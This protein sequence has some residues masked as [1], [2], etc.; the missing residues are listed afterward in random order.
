MREIIIAGNWKMNT[1]P[2]E[3]L[4]LAREVTKNVEG[5]EG[6]TVVI[7]PPAT[8]LVGINQLLKASVAGSKCKPVELGAQNVHW[9]E[10]GAFTGE[11][12]AAMLE[13]L[14]CRWVIIGHS[15]RRTYF[16]ETNET[17]NRRLIR[18]LGTRLRPIVCIGESL[19]QRESGKTF[20]VLKQQLE[21]CLNGA[22]L[23]GD[24]G[25]VIAYEPVW[26]IGTGRT[27]TPDQ[28]QEAHRFIREQLTEMFDAESADKTVIQYGGS[29]ND[30]NAAELMACPDLDGALI[31]GVSL[32][33]GK[34]GAVVHAA[35]ESV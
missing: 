28:A 17:V 8:H 35:S 3:G 32:H 34:F 2:S 7:C 1:T 13:S 4:G 31:G 20:D 6:V 9:E 24:G 25:L 26:A 11:L 12:S 16:N 23:D 19:E 15:E 10:S 27:A 14:G 5:I 22:R 30:E 33:A 29:V 18:A 21:I